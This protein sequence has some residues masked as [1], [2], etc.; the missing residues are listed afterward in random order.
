MRNPEQTPI[1][2]ECL[3]ARLQIEKIDNNKNKVT[4]LPCDRVFEEDGKKYCVAYLWPAKKWIRGCP[5]AQRELTEEQQHK[6][7]PLKA[8]KRSRRKG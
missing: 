1:V 2:D 6:L 4:Q 8:S 3:T 5:L 7:N